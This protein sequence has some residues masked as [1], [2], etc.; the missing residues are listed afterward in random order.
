MVV[1]LMMFQFLDKRQS[2]HME[3]SSNEFS[4]KRFSVDLGKS[5]AN[6]FA[7][8]QFPDAKFDYVMANPPFNVSDWEGEK[9]ERMFVGNMEDHQLKCKL[10][11]YNLFWK[12]NNRCMLYQMVLV[13][14]HLRI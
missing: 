3:T 4:N 14:Y 9:Y 6:T 13:P 8:D 5:N 1:K 10:H 12:L 7:N 2:N 11:G